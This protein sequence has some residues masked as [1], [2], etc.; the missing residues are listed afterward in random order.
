VHVSWQTAEY[1]TTGKVLWGL[2][3]D[4]LSNAQG[5]GVT[6]TSHAVDIANLN[7]DTIYYFQAVSKDN[8]GREKQSAVIAI[9]TQ[10]EPVI[11]PVLPVWDITDLGGVASQTSVTVNWNTSDYATTG[12]VLWGT[13]PGALTNTVSETGAGFA[14]SVTVTGLTADTIYYFQVVAVDD[15]GQEKSTAEIPLST[16]AQATD[17]GDGGTT[18]PTWSVV[19]FDGTTTADSA[20]MIWQTP[21]VNTKATLK[22]GTSPSDLSLQVITVDTAAQAQLTTVSGLS[23]DTAYYFQVIAVDSAGTTHESVVIMKRTK[24]Q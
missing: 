2:A 16:L 15:K 20:T 21:G 14:H 1:A 19:G 23:A 24:A 12:R 17:P 13:A 3:A 8:L 10:P 6:D 22:V 11:P 4:A 9:R 7:A 5:D 18:I